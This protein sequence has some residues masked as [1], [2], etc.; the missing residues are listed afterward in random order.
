M[1]IAIVSFAPDHQ[2]QILALSLRAWSPVFAK[3]EPAVPSYVYRAFYPGGWRARQATDIAEFLGNEGRHAWVAIR[4]G[5]VLGWVGARMHPE[6]RMGEIYIIAVDPDHQRHGIATALMNHAI[7]EMRGAGLAIVM[8]ETG[9][10]PG[11]DASRAAYEAVGFER[12]P[13]ARYFRKL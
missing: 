9:D 12:W 1:T 5:N 13:V 6:D 4:A 8:V 11:H 2:E 7:A 10:H 3:L